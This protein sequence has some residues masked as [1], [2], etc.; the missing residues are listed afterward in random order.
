MRKGGRQKYRFV[1][2]RGII[3]SEGVCIAGYSSAE[4]FPAVCSARPASRLNV[5]VH[6]PPKEHFLFHRRA[7]RGAPAKAFLL[8]WAT[9]RLA[10][11]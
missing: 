6:L 4:K 10:P 7:G 9:V 11:L 5:T 8:F 1:K 3:C 2:T